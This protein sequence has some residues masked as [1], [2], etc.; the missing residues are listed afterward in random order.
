VIGEVIIRNTG[1][2]FTLKY[3]IFVFF[4]DPN[5]KPFIKTADSK[6]QDRNQQTTGTSSIN[7]I[8][9][10]FNVNKLF[11]TFSSRLAH[12]IKYILFFFNS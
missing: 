11:K 1:R 12:S 7:T 6:R 9:D 5:I 10:V 3:K 8:R 2:L 4:K